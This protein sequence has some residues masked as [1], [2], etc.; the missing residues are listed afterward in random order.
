MLFLLLLSSSSV[1][2]ILVFTSRIPVGLPTKCELF[3]TSSPNTTFQ[4]S[5][6]SSEFKYLNS[7]PTTEEVSDYLQTVY[8]RS[9]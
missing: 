4:Y 8:N 3:S 1:V 2:K 5:P 6:R 9:S 7:V